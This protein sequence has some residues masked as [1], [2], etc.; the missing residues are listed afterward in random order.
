MTRS[1]RRAPTG[2]PKLAVAYLRISTT[3]DRQALGLEAQRQAIE[4]WSLA[5][6][7]TI[8]SWHTE[9]VTGGADLDRRPVLLES[10]AAV[11]AHGAGALVVHKLDRFSRSAVAAALA[12]AELRRGGAQLTVVEGHN[13]DDPTSDLI[14]SILLAVG[15]FERQMIKARVRSALRVKIEKGER[16]GSVPY[17]FS[18]GCDGKTLERDEHESVKRERLRELRAS[19]LTVRAVLAQATIEGLTNRKGR[20]FTVAALHK[21]VRDVRR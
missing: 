17:G 20:P 15:A 3:T 11:I 12:E 8:I 14:R 5:N 18:V 13:G 9:A 16:A 7:V 19:G 6:G 10:I 1:K 2:D 21:I 4:R